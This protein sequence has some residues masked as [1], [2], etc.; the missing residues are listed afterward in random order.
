MNGPELKKLRKDLGLSIADAARQ[1]EVTPRTWCRWEAGDQKIPQ[2]ALKLFLMLND[3][4]L[5]ET[6]K[7]VAFLLTVGSK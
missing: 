4:K 7:R 6:A 2:G 5:K 3:D 1:V